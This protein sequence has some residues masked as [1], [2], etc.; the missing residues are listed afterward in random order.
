MASITQV[1]VLSTR[2]AAESSGCWILQKWH[3]SGVVALFI[4][5][6][7][8]LQLFQYSLSCWTTA[9]LGRLSQWSLCYSISSEPRALFCGHKEGDTQTGNNEQSQRSLLEEAEKAS[10]SELPEL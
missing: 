6:R 5:Q 4:L 7:C 2:N 9:L 1:C 10:G 3:H 8:V